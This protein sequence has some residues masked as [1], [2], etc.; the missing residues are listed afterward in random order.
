MINGEVERVQ[1]LAAS[2]PAAASAALQRERLQVKRA[3]YRK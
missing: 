2:M 3:L 1:L